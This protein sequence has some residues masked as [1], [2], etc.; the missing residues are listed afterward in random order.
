MRLPPHPSVPREGLD[1]LA[2]ELGM[3]PGSVRL[4]PDAGIFNAIY[5]IGSHFVLRVPRRH[6]AHFEALR[7]EA[8]VVPIARL[9]GVRTPALVRYDAG[10]GLLDVPYAVYEQ[11]K[12]SP[13]EAAAG[14]IRTSPNAWEQLGRD[15]ALLHRHASGQPGSAGLPVAQEMPEPEDLIDQRAEEGWLTIS[16]ARWMRA[17]LEVLTSHALAGARCVTHGDI[18]ASNLMVD[19]LGNYQA[20]IDWGSARWDDPAHDFAGVPLHVIPL[21]LAGYRMG[22]AEAAGVESRIV[23]RHIQLALWLLPRGAVPGRSWA[24]RPLPMLL[25]A[26]RFF[27]QPP[28]GWQDLAPPATGP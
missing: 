9:V 25:A 26:V 23:R 2:A 3:S 10:G 1:A 20:V 11:V 8:I 12:G 27:V 19:E 15:L 22:G 17:W 14:D 16:A 18:Q 21:M 6:P 28:P 4:L 5:L 24:E 13:L 7:A